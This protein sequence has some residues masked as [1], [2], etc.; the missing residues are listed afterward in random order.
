MIF[1]NVFI[2]VCYDL[3]NSHFLKNGLTRRMF[4]E[5]MQKPMMSNAI[6]TEMVVSS[7]KL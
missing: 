4:D 7:A 3:P 6:T 1:R 2:I 5:M